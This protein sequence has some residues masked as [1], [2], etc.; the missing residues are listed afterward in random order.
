[1]AGIDLK[2]AVWSLCKELRECYSFQL[3]MT[4]STYISNMN[5]YMNL[6]VRTK[7][8]PVLAQS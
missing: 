8:N 4:C 1:M 2:M 6:D 3:R 7:I 5:N